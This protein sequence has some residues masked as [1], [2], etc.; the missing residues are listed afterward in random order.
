MPVLV[1][2]GVR[3]GNQVVVTE[4]TIIERVEAGRPL[5]KM[6]VPLG[7][8]ALWTFISILWFGIIRFVVVGAVAIPWVV[9]P[10]TAATANSWMLLGT[11]AAVSVAAFLTLQTNV[12]NRDLHRAMTF[13]VI[14]S[15]V[16]FHI[17]LGVG[18]P[19]VENASGGANAIAW[20]FQAAA[21]AAGTGAGLAVVRR[22]RV[23][24]ARGPRALPS[25]A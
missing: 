16:V 1:R 17:N 21:V 6:G 10:K 15:A 8:M 22:R 2:E 12:R 20:V 5:E 25:S 18:N 14:A 3:M 7:E 11:P 9:L 23:R 19:F 24:A 13:V 4:A